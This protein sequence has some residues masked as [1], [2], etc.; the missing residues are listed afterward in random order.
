MM[1]EKQRWRRMVGERYT[2]ETAKTGHAPSVFNE[3]KKLDDQT[4]KKYWIEMGELCIQAQME[5]V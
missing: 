5:S 1:I 4:H 2:Q 3:R